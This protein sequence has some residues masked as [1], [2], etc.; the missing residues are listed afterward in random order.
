MVVDDATPPCPACDFNQ[1]CRESLD[2]AQRMR[3]RLTL[4]RD[5]AL[6]LPDDAADVLRRDLSVIES[7]NISLK[8]RSAY[9]TSIMHQMEV[10]KQRL[11]TLIMDTRWTLYYACAR[12]LPDDI[13]R[14][15]FQFAFDSREDPKISDTLRHNREPWT[16]AQVCRR[17]RNL[18]LATPELWTVVGLDFDFHALRQDTPAA[19][20][21]RLSLFLTRSTKRLLRVTIA[22]PTKT[23]FN[24]WKTVLDLIFRESRRWVSLD[25]RSDQRDMSNI[26]SSRTYPNLRHFALISRRDGAD[27]WSIPWENLRSCSFTKMVFPA[28]YPRLCAV[29]TLTLADHRNVSPWNTDN[30]NRSHNIVFPRLQH[31]RVVQNNKWF[32]PVVPENAS[33]AAYFFACVHAPVLETLD[34][35]FGKDIAA[36]LPTSF[37]G[38]PAT[39]RGLSVTTRGHGITWQALAGLLQLTVS[40]EDLVV[41]LQEAASSEMLHGLHAGHDP[42]LLP[43]LRRLTSSRRDIECDDNME[44]IRNSRAQSM[45]CIPLVYC[46][47]VD[48]VPVGTA[49]P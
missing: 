44:A 29:T 3:F 47:A 5:A 24:D 26:L 17:W 16:F 14:I 12:T 28:T 10:E 9:M 20:E 39:I 43:C 11:E 6:D 34:L 40:V 23:R 8:K 46:M 37:L 27:S 15:V 19:V 1:F 32:P 38:N 31:L 18:V 30:F 2:P 48:L 13:L 33:L 49:S 35:S 22:M 21:S 25:L 7:H 41:N 45:L 4:W 42:I 36:D